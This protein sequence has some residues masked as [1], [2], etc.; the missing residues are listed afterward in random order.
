MSN[1]KAL[2]PLVQ[3]AVA[4]SSSYEQAAQFLKAQ[5]IH[6]LPHLPQLLTVAIYDPIKA[7]TLSEQQNLFKACMTDWVSFSLAQKADVIHQNDGGVANKIIQTFRTQVSKFGPVTTQ[8]AA[9]DA[10]TSNADPTLARLQLSRLLLK[11]PFSLHQP[12]TNNSNRQEIVL[13]YIT[14]QIWNSVKSARATDEDQRYWHAYSSLLQEQS[15]SS[16]LLWNTSSSFREHEETLLLSLYSYVS[17]SAFSDPG[18]KEVIINAWTTV[19]NSLSS[20]QQRTAIIKPTHSLLMTAIKQYLTPTLNPDLKEAENLGRLKLIEQMLL[21][22][23]TTDLVKIAHWSP[24]IETTAK[25]KD[26]TPAATPDN[27]IPYQNGFIFTAIENNDLELVRLLDQ[28][29]KHPLIGTN[30]IRNKAGMNI[31]EAAFINCLRVRPLAADLATPVL[32]YLIETKTSEITQDSISQHVIKTVSKRKPAW[33]E[34][35]QT[36]QL[37]AILRNDSENIKAAQLS[38]P[39]SQGVT[40]DVKKETVKK[41]RRL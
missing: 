18:A 5:A 27:F 13:A 40:D 10:T 1:P 32:K 24:K 20:K 35:I 37:H 6:L 19:W 22:A 7:L 9:K 8:E 12:L 2:H 39:D 33:A 31:L 14:T 38:E 15:T 21:S 29:L 41:S 23:T 16:R 4:A 34:A 11:L 30:S 28:Y 17:K 36:Q 3:D 25:Q 26:K